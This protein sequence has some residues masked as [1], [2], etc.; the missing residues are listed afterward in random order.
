LALRYDVA[1]LRYLCLNDQE[2]VRRIHVAVRDDLWGTVPGIVSDVVLHEESASFEI[3]W[4]SEHRE[5]DI[6]F[7]WQGRLTGDNSG[8]VTFE[9]DGRALS[10]FKTN[11]VGCCVLFPNAATS[12]R[13]RVTHADGL[14]VECCLPAEIT[15][16]QPVNGFHDVR[17]VQFETSSDG[18]IEIVCEGDQFEVEDQRNWLDA[19]FKLYS[20]PLSAPAPYQVERGTPIRQKVCIRLLSE[21]GT[22][23]TLVHV[24]PIG[25]NT[26]RRRTR[27]GD[28]DRVQIQLDDSRILRLPKLGA[29]APP[30]SIVSSAIASRLRQLRLSHLRVDLDTADDATLER[31]GSLFDAC[32]TLEVPVELA[33]H[34]PES[35]SGNETWIDLVSQTAIRRILVHQQGSACTTQH[36]I[37]RVR[38]AVRRR[39]IDIGFGTRGDLFELN[40]DRPKVTG[41]TFVFWS[42]TPQWHATDLLSLAE[43]PETVGQQVR[44]MREMYSEMPQVVSP[45]TL[46]PRVCTAA[47]AWVTDDRPA[48]APA[49][50]ARQP[51]LACAAWTLAMISQFARWGVTAATFYECLGPRGLMPSP[52]TIMDDIAPS[53]FPVWLVWAA[54]AGHSEALGSRTSHPESAAVLALR[55]YRARR[56]VIASLRDEPQNVEIEGL[57]R[58]PTLRS[59]DEANVLSSMQQPESFLTGD[60]E[61]VNVANDRILLRLERFGIA[62]IDDTV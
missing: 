50:D 51:S 54:L 56:L 4:L 30:G 27:H 43:T 49:T 22:P 48:Q 36:A 18:W 35:S 62:L 57:F 3:R 8:A 6:H 5:R 11:R 59:L 1:D 28:S 16:S 44:R 7:V 55:N 42:M 14:P 12:R 40:V 24:E 34:L 15:P 2:I 41:A 26:D 10:S 25:R 37:D 52:N 60:A 31:A 9:M 61:T 32:A 58:R 20:R 19:S 53:V 47:G 29:A 45:I 23:A 33:L 38:G 21:S 46:L 39:S 13:C 17:A